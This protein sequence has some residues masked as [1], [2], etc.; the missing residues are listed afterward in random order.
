MNRTPVDSSNIHSIGHDETGL[1][2][3]FHRTGCSRMSKPPKGETIQAGCNCIGGDVWHYPG[4]P[5]D[6]HGEIVKSESPGAAFHKRVKS[7]KHAL[8]GLQFPGI[9]RE[10]VGYT[11][12]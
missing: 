9:K 2:V 3:Q 5:A 10:P 12:I 1:E 7:A 4:V 6:L 11:G 8:G